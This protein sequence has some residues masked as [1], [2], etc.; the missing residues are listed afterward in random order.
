MRDNRSMPS[1][2]II[3][4][5]GYPDTRRAVEWLCGAFGFRERLRIAEH[6]SQLEFGDG[7]VV[8]TDL[9][10]TA[11]PDVAHSIMVRVSN[12]D[13]HFA[14]AQG[15]GAVVV[16]FPASY[17]FGERQYTV[18]DIGGH[19]WTFSETVENVEPRTWGGELLAE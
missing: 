19:T 7:T 1:S 5:L 15:Y 11:T 8:V 18:R 17:P 9:G 13:S 2:S 4:V 16:N 10:A 12:V 14:H 6:R 3:P